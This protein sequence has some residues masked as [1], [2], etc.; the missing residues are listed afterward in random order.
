MRL[1]RGGGLGWTPCVG[2]VLATILFTAAAEESAAAGAGLLFVYGAAMTVPFIVAA[3]FIGPFMALMR[4][5]RAYLG[6]IEKAM[7]AFLILFAV[8]IATD[9]INIIAGFLLEYGPDIGVLR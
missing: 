9:S 2:P 7:G 1:D 8:L 5:M 4:R 6:A 3:A